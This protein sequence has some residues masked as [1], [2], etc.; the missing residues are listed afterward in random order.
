M[1]AVLLLAAFLFAALIGKLIYIEVISSSELQAKAL[2]QWMRDIPLQAERGEIYDVNGV[3]LA[4]SETAYTIYARPTSVTDKQ[5]T[6]SILASVLGLDR[7]QTYKKLQSRISEIT[8]AKKVTK[9]KMLELYQSEV[10]G[11][12]YSQT[13]SRVY[14][15]GDF[16]TQ[17]I[18]F[19]N[20]D[21]DGQTGVE[22][23]YNKYLA[24]TDGYLLTETDLIGRELD[25]GL[26]R[27]V[28]GKKGGSAYLS[29]DYYIQ[30]FAEKAVA[31]VM[32]KHGAKS[33][34]CI[35]MD[36]N[37]GAVYA[38]A[39]APSFDLNNVP[40]D[41]VAELFSNAKS[42][43]VSNVMEPGSTF[44]I[45]TA[46]AGL[47]AGVISANTRTYCPGY[48]IVDG[49]R[50]KCWRTI[51]HG[52][53]S[54]YEGVQNS[55]NCLFM[56]TAMKLGAKRFYDV[57]G[58]LELAQETGIDILGEAKG[59][60]IPLADVKTVDIARIGFGQAIAVTPI[61][62]LR[63]AS[64]VING[65]NLVTPYVL[66]RVTDAS[67]ETVFKTVPA[68][69]SG[70]I[71]EATS[72]LMRDVLESVVLNGSGRNAQVAG[73]RIGGKTGTAQKYVNGAIA[74]GKYT[75]TF[76]GFAPADNPQY[77]ALMVV[78]EPQGAYYG[79]IVAA[80]YIGDVF[81]GIFAYKNIPPA[82]AA[83]PKETFLMPN[84]IGMSPEEAQ[85]ETAKL[86]MFLEIAGEGGVVQSQT[87][88]AGE[89][90][91]S[92]NVV[93]IDIG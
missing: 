3:L 57:I 61:E 82:V 55:C 28:P 71:S 58:S 79:S 19:T 25:T 66:D 29:L 49:Q 56:D 23:Y 83:V 30:S 32:L 43:L 80:P 76:I 63:A 38:M 10:S 88:A 46:A 70:V 18:G 45:I 24:G 93:V 4:D 67:G 81:R 89:R 14:P 59:L 27:Y 53:Q 50:I 64:A 2:S 39:Q 5:K 9:E 91:T 75:S 35:V 92:D 77:I 69:K 15:Y 17:I 54:F 51:G 62:L 84:L 68:V 41:N 48:R 47:E 26:T 12:Y 78:D 65:G 20:L 7:E 8:I 44:K 36:P 86:K 74:R 31:D 42:T 1:L 6:A 85:K 11:I 90:V 72:S 37:T 34:S 40:R 87:P 21:A 33:A 73:Y 52:S 22:A 60:T 13:I 16:M